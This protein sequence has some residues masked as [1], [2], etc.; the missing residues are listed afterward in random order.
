MEI[1]QKTVT[2]ILYSFEYALKIRDKDGPT[3]RL[4]S[5]M[6]NFKYEA[7]SDWNQ[8]RELTSK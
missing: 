8:Y 2:L 5:Y 4:L 3:L 6:G 7:P 1:I